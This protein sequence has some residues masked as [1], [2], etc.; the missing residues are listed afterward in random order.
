MYSTAGVFLLPLSFLF[1]LS[2]HCVCVCARPR[3]S[4]AGLGMDE[5]ESWAIFASLR[6]GARTPSGGKGEN[7]NWDGRRV[8]R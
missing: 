8:Q 1:Y 6:L 5:S 2:A 4:V 3:V 7:C